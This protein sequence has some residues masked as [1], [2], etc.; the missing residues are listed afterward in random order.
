VLAHR[1]HPTGETQMARRSTQDVLVDLLG[2]V[3]VPAPRL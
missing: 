1:L 3:R 2:R